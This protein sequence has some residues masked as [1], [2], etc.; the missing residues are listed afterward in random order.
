MDRRP[1]VAAPESIWR[2]FVEKAKEYPDAPIYHYGTYE[3]RAIESL[4][5][6]YG[7]DVTGIVKRLVNINSFTAVRLKVEQNQLVAGIE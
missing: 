7:T 6:R 3:V 1:K 5:K 2:K 4:A